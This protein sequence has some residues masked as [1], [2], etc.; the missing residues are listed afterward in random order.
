MSD[1]EMH[2]LYPL[3]Y[4]K[5][6]YEGF[7][8]HT[9][10]RPFAF[11]V[12]GWAGLQRHAA[13]WTGDT[14]G[15]AGTLGGCLNL[16]LSGH[17]MVTVDMEVTTPEGIHFGFLLPWAQLN[18]WNYWRHPWLQGD[19]L[20]ATFTEYAHLR[21][22]LIPYL[23]HHARE[24]SRSGV[25]LLR[26]MPLEFPD[27]PETYGLVRQYM[28]GPDLLVGAFTRRVYLPEGQWYDYWTGRKYAGKQW[29][30]PELP[31]RRGGPLFVRAGAIL[32]LGPVMDYVGQKVT[33]ELCAQAFLG[34]DATLNLYEDDGLTL[35]Y[36]Q[37]DYRSTEIRQSSRPG[38]ARVA[39]DGALGSFDGASDERI[40]SFQIYGAERPN[41]VL[42]NG[43]A[44]REA[45]AS[46]EATSL[47]E[48]SS[49]GEAM[50]WRWDEARRIVSAWAGK[51]GRGVNIE[52][53]L[54]Y[55]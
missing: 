1:D 43:A 17:G 51:R 23:Y 47:G 11:T 22:R 48:A 44:I 16:S 36:Q 7:L 42:I 34:A 39:V 54:L 20:K 27:D 13:T 38:L 40:V 15:E 2:N 29:V 49:L 10:R 52:L 45:S 6:M 28:L 33:D 30:E 53:A 12:A 26:A 18:S 4:S 55:S 19:E 35:A 32:P 9:G 41:R 24:S 25:P 8:A 31:P 5:Q 3:L 37:G 14:G 46:G 21:Y 50:T